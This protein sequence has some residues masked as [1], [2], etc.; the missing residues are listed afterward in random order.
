VSYDVGIDGRDPHRV[1]VTRTHHGATVWIDGRAHRADLA[2]GVVRLD[3]R[4]ASV[5]VYVEGDV[6]HVHALG[7]TRRVELVDP[8][9]RSQ[10]AAEHADV[11]TAPMPGSVVSTPV[12]AGE[13]VSVGQPLVV[14]ESMK[15]QSEL[16]ATRD[17]VVARLH[18]A[19]GDT[20]DRGAALVTMEPAA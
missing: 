16:V 3:D 10:R 14:I 17:G 15:M 20:F 11:V 19:V 2:D 4:A 1:A 9:E 7:R 18:L 8:A 12:A 5:H 6:A 13:A